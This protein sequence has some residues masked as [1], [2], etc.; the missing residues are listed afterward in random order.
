MVEN[1]KDSS[2]ATEEKSFLSVIVHSFFIIPF[3]IAVFAL[4]LF[5]AINL[6]TRE[7]R[8][9]YDYLEDVKTGAMNKR[10][11]GAFELS[12]ILANPKLVPD[13]PRFIHEMVKAF[14]QAK[15]DNNLV[16]QYLALAMG[17]SGK[18]EF[19]K[20]LI[21]AVPQE[22]EENIPSIIY[23]LGML[24]TKEAVSVIE[25]FVEHPNAF[26]RSNA[27]V[28]LGNIGDAKA[29]GTLR[30]VLADP[31]PNV[32]WG[33]AISLAQMGDDS[34]KGILMKLLDRSY[35]TGFKEVD[36]DEQNQL[37]LLTIAASKNIKNKDL[38]NKIKSLANSDPNMQV[39]ATSLKY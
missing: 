28:A 38:E 5:A 23:A 7:N 18:T 19:V 34:G 33:A 15:Y 26:I 32:T 11:Q 17:R 3:L 31:E 21:D 22:K 16:R 27:V 2:Q 24:K 29:I 30:K 12:K 9:V 8:G 14:D 37:M 39:R 20:P 36:A 35:L 1:S 10:W 25:P 4:L 13:D 6:L